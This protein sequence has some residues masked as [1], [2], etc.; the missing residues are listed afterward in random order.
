MEWSAAE[1]DGVAILCAEQVLFNCHRLLTAEYFKVRFPELEV[2]H[3]GLAYS[4]YGEE[5]GA[6]PP[7]VLKI[8]RTFMVG[9][10]I[11]CF[12]LSA[13]CCAVLKNRN[14]HAIVLHSSNPIKTNGR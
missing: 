2:V 6:V 4:R 7:A 8:T 11:F 1:L 3:P 13:T 10:E 12:I 14:I 5:V 9:T